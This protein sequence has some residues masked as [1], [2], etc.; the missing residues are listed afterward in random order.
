MGP[1]KIPGFV[2]QPD[3]DWYRHTWDDLADDPSWDEPLDAP[4]RTAAHGEFARG[5]TMLLGNAAS[6][7]SELRSFRDYY[8]NC[9][10]EVDAAVGVVLDALTASGQAD[11]TVVVYTSDHGELTGAHGLFGKGPCAYDANIRLPLIIVD[12][13]VDGGGRSPAN[14]SQVDLVPTMVSLASGRPPSAGV[15]PVGQNL[16]HLVDEP[17]GAGRT[18]ALFLS[19]GLMFV[20]G[21]WVMA[22]GMRSPD[23]VT[24]RD[25]TKH[26]LMRTIVTD[27]YKFSRYFSPAEHHTPRSMEEL[28]ERNTIELFD[29]ASDPNELHNLAGSAKPELV[30]ALNMELGDLVDTEIGDDDGHWMPALAGAPWIGRSAA[31]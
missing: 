9:I 27:H 22:G 4:G 3:A 2:G 8:I 21:D 13:E 1:R 17:A 7:R 19:D 14:V 15:G 11:D 26:G 28:H 23:Q 29:L 5:M 16:A 25:F 31:G 10:R 30:E 24:G 18:S 6:S 12:P 20:D